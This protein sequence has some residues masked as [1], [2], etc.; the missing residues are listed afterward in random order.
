VTARILIVEDN[1]ANLEL[2]VYLL[3]AFGY[4]PLSARDGEA[5]LAMI[6]QERPDLVL[7]DVQIPKLD[8]YQVA[9]QVQGDSG[10]KSIPLVAVTAYAM[11]GDR[12]KLLAAGFDGYLAKPIDPETFVKRVEEFLPVRL[13]SNGRRPV[14]ATPAPVASPAVQLKR[15]TILVVDNSLANLDLF[16]SILQSGGYTVISV[17]SVD[18]ALVVARRM[19]LDLVLTDLHM[20]ER[21]GFDLVRTIRNDPELHRLKVVIHSAT[22]M[23]PKDRVEALALGADEFIDRV[24]EPQQLLAQM[25]VCLEHR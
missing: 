6:R 2:M 12:D 20:P 23:S 21:N 16:R 7:C 8:G 5:G 11:V 3:S 9:A 25:E 14:D 24:L 19:P 13:H 15:Q 4:S 18:E 17:P 1:S 10:L 22:V